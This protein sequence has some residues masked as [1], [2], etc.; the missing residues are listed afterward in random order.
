MF[1]TK[2]AVPTHIAT[3]C[4][5]TPTAERVLHWMGD[6][7]FLI[8]LI[9]VHPKS[10]EITLSHAFKANTCKEGRKLFYDYCATA[11]STQVQEVPPLPAWCGRFIQSYHTNNR[12]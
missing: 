1:I 11:N 2:A 3:E 9:I 6:G 5:R 8:E 12:R 7:R 10:V 4:F